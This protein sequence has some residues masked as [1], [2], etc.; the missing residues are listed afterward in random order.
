V[1]GDTYAFIVRIWHETQ[2]E[3]GN[4]V[5]WRGS[6][7]H[8]GSDQRLYFQDMEGILRFIEEQTGVNAGHPGSR[9]KALLAR[10]RDETA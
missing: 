3:E 1:Q 8:V 6:I 10:I 7:D 9:W 5:A 4:I 2:D